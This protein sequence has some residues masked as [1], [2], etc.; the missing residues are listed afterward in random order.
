MVETKEESLGVKK[1]KKLMEPK[2][3]VDAKRLKKQWVLIIVLAAL[4]IF[5]LSQFFLILGNRPPP[6][7]QKEIVEADVASTGLD[8]DLSRIGDLE[9][10]QEELEKK[11]EAL[12]LS[13]EE[14]KLQTQ[15][16]IEVSRQTAEE[17]KELKEL[18]LKK[19]EMQET[20]IA[21]LTL[22]AKKSSSPNALEVSIGSVEIEQIQERKHVAETIPAG[23]IVRCV[24]V[25]GASVSTGIGT[26][27]GSRKVL[28]K[29]T[30]NGW[31]PAGVRVALKD[32]L[33]MCSATANLAEERV[34][35]RGDRMNLTYPDGY[36]I[37]TEIAAYVSGEDGQ[38]GVR[39]ALIDKNWASTLWA[40][41]A[42]SVGE[43]GKAVQSHSPL[44]DLSR[45]G[46][47]DTNFIINLDTLKQGGVQGG[48]TALDKMTEHL[49]KE[50]EKNAPFLILDSLRHVDLIFLHDCEIGENNMKEKMRIK[51]A[52]EKEQRM[53]G[54]GPHHS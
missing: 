42:S 13:S 12:T 14:S 27:I 23:T 17:L 51:R 19:I 5:F 29:P 16:L 40:G 47:T 22:P 20:K 2:K 24:I 39:C 41:L 6:S 43:V 30:S 28:L 32:S 35:V 52:L 38:E 21:T 10:T 53:K 37:T 26:P 50:K 54:N 18:L 45:L 49:L 44:M 34:Y 15:E 1:L 33:I 36:T 31:L 48:S 11:V 9:L 4:T 25:S 7:S 46:K 3:S 8:P